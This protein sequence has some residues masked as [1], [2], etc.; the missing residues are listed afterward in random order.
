MYGLSSFQ[1]RDGKLDQFLLK[2]NI[3]KEK[4]CILSIDIV[5]SYQK[6]P[7]SDIQIRFLMSRTIWIFLIFFNN[8]FYWNLPKFLIDLIFNTVYFLKWCPIFDNSTLL[9]Q[10]YTI[11]HPSPG[12]SKTHIAITCIQNLNRIWRVTCRIKF[13]FVEICFIIQKMTRNW[14]NNE[15]VLFVPKNT[16]WIFCQTFEQRGEKI[17]Q[18]WTRH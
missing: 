6:V 15:L 11:L 18:I 1:T 7:K 9:G 13:C 14:P 2:N 12:N 5:P 3:L 16:C 17:G 8:L 10:K 4:Y